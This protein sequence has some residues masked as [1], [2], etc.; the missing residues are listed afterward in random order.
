M[1]KKQQNRGPKSKATKSVATLDAPVFNYFSV[2]CNIKATKPALVKT[3]DAEGTLGSWRC[4]G[5][6]KSCKV[7]RVKAEKAEIKSEVTA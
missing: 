5:C 1:P 3:P 7:N 2:C 4:V 6:G